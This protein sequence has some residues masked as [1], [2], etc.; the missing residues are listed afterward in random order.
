MCTLF[1]RFPNE[2]CY[3]DIFYLS[4]DICRIQIVIY[5]GVS[6]IGRAMISIRGNQIL[7][8]AEYFARGEYFQKDDTELF[9][10]IKKCIA[11]IPV[12]ID[13]VDIKECLTSALHNSIDI[14]LPS[15]N[16]GYKPWRPDNNSNISHQLNHTINSILD[17]TNDTSIFELDTIC[18]L[19][20]YGG[21]KIIVQRD[22]VIFKLIEIASY[23]RIFEEAM[24]ACI[25]LCYI[26]KIYSNIIVTID[27]RS[28]EKWYQCEQKM[29][30][31]YWNQLKTA[32]ST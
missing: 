21:G 28:T 3:W 30:F 25:I 24:M 26:A 1:E 23:A 29:F 4:K 11:G 17:P 14:P 12:T 7:Q 16:Y 2:T 22:D 10:Y 31:H 18:K 20:E 15:F 32:T 8:C 9:T 6:I 13:T 19:L 27:I 5:N